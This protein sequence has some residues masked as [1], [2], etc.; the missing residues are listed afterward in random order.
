[1]QQ[2]NDAELWDRHFRAE[3]EFAAGLRQHSHVGSNHNILLSFGTL[4]SWESRLLCLYPPGTGWPSYTPGTGFPFCRLLRLSAQVSVFV[5]PPGTEWPSYTPGTGF[6][7]CR[8][9]RLEAQVSV[10]VFPRKRVAQ[11][12]P[13]ALGSLSVASY[14][15]RP[16]SPSLY[17]PGTEWPSYTPGYWVPFLSPPMIVDPGL[18][19]CIPQEHGGP[20]IPRVL[21]SLSVASYD[22][23]VSDPASTRGSSRGSLTHF[24]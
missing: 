2:R 5:S 12:Y 4:P 20:A 6:P 22:S 9:L 19:R 10:V 21:G 8:L 3:Q 14:D 7:F 11:L 17:P 1:V 24:V 23:Q 18:R 13:R 15:S 16:R